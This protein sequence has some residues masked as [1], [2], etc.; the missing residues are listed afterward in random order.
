MGNEKKLIINN[1]HNLNVQ[2][3][4]SKTANN[5]Q[6]KDESGENC[7]SK[8]NNNDNESKRCENV[9]KDFC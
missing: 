9:C 1:G 3:I 7:T 2:L 5:K 8:N 6:I 4:L